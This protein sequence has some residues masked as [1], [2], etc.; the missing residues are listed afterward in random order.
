[1]DADVKPEPLG[2]EESASPTPEAPRRSR[3]ACAGLAFAVVY[4]PQLVPLMVGPL[5]ECDH[6]V[7]N[8]AKLFPLIPGA[9]AALLTGRISG[10]LGVESAIAAGIVAVALLFVA[11]L[12]MRAESPTR[13]IT[14]ALIMILLA[15]QAAGVASMLRA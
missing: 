10:E 7:E 4:L 3:W 8:Y 9:F 15:L 11:Y 12:C 5:R 14:S 13:Q 6:C 2:E 1:M